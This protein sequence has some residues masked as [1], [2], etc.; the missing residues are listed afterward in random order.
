MPPYK[1][2][3]AELKR[4]DRETYDLFLEDLMSIT[5]G[6]GND[7]PDVDDPMGQALLLNQLIICIQERRKWGWSVHG[8]DPKK[9]IN[10]A[11]I[12]TGYHEDYRSGKKQMWPET[13]EGDGHT[14]A[15]ALLA[16]YLA[17]LRA[18]FV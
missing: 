10:S 16:A 1:D 3:L 14:P 17:T 12:T 5:Y 9:A 8:D 6:D 2:K 11:Q 15:S 18:G 7:C 13:R 4:V